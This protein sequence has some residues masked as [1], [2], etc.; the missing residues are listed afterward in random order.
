MLDRWFGFQKLKL[1]NIKP[2]L[3]AVPSSKFVSNS[4]T[5]EKCACAVSTA[6]E[7]AQ[8]YFC[9]LI[10]HAIV[11][12]SSATKPELKIFS[13]ILLLIG[14]SLRFKVI[15]RIEHQFSTW[16]VNFSFLDYLKRKHDTELFFIKFDRVRQ[17]KAILVIHA[18]VYHVLWSECNEW[19]GL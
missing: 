15:Y 8:H 3:V 10:A 18:S 9:I 11:W 4:N 12:C 14:Y 6:H 13:W 19:F 17:Q 5:P 7:Y 1:E 2:F 16:G